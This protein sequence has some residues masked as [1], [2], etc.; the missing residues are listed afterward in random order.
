VTPLLAT[1]LSD[2]KK[3]LEGIYAA[4]EFVLG[5]SPKQ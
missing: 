3:Y 4:R 5:D 1:F 2:G